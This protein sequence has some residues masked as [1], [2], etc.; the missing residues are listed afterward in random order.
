MKGHAEW[1][2]QTRS[3]VGA[4]GDEIDEGSEGGSGKNSGC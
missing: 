4:E 3:S 2:E 1:A